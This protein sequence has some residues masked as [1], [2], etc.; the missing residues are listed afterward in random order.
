MKKLSIVLS[1]LL[2]GLLPSMAFNI[3]GLKPKGTVKVG[4]ISSQ[5]L[6]A[7]IS[8]SESPA[9]VAASGA[10]VGDGGGAATIIA[11]SFSSDAPLTEGATYDLDI[12]GSSDNEA[13]V[14]ITFA[15]A[16]AGRSGASTT[17]GSGN[18]TEITGKVK[19]SKVTANTVTL[20]VNA[21]ATNTVSIKTNS[22]GESTT[23]T[24]AKSIPVKINVK[25]T[26]Q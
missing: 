10:S 9:V 19:V 13:P 24:V 6:V 2:I 8:S 16:K 15:A 17:A 12:L 11:I 23:T 25:A 21:K 14:S 1:L 20:L 7:T 18:D 3:P 22:D 26:I 5:L 4:G